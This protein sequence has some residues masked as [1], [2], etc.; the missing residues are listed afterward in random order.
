MNAAKSKMIYKQIPLSLSEGFDSDLELTFNIKNSKVDPHRHFHETYSF[1]VSLKGSTGFKIKDKRYNLGPRE[2]MIIH[3]GEVHQHGFSSTEDSSLYYA[4]Y[5][6]LKVFNKMA[7]LESVAGF[8]TPFFSDSLLRDGHL[9]GHINTYCRQVFTH[10]LELLHEDEIN[11]RLFHHIIA[12]PDSKSNFTTGRIG[13]EEPRVSLLKDYLR[14]NARQKIRLE[15]LADLV[16][17]S[18]GQTLRIFK[19]TTGMSPYVYLLNLR[20]NSSTD[21]LRK[22]KTIAET[23]LL[24]GFYDQSHFHRN[25]VRVMRVSPGEYRRAVRAK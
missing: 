18:P 25:F 11:Y 24:S 23:A 12:H 13:L 22:G 5:I 2:I 4:L 3:P 9:A 8:D 17:L 20:I 21:L 14:A 10:D 19:K 7:D 15:E 1:G 6:P 16:H